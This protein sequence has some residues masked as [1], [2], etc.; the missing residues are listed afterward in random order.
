MQYATLT[1]LNLSDEFFKKDLKERY[2]ARIELLA[3]TLSFLGFEVVK[4]EGAYY[5][6]VKFRGVKALSS[7]DDPMEAAMFLL[8]E[9]GVACVPG[10]N[11]YSKA[12]QE[13]ALFLRF[14]ACRSEAD[15]AEACR[16]LRKHLA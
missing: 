16:R 14:A 5:L 15:V 13:G 12:V 4:P 9:V 3:S 8:E 11:F 7:F 1:Y 10:N 2:V 6:F